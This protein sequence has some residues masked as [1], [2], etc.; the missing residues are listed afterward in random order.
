MVINSVRKLEM[1]AERT[2][3]Y[4]TSLGA[5]AGTSTNG[6]GCGTNLPTVLVCRT[7]GHAHTSTHTPT[8]GAGAARV[9]QRGGRGSECAL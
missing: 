5:A 6:W 2:L 3:R 4:S 9:Q 1:T 8:P 7:S